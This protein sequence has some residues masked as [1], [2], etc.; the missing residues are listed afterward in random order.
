MGVMVV[1][2]HIKRFFLGA[3]ILTLLIVVLT[4]VFG[5]L[6]AYFQVGS[7]ILLYASFAYVIGLL[8]RC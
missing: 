7:L 4:A 3:L 8:V 5:N 1:M 2:E 6:G